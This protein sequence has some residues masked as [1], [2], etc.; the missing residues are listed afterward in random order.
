MININ[1]ELLTKIIEKHLENDKEL[2]NI[3]LDIVN[4]INNLPFGTETSIAQ[5]IDYNPEISFTEPLTQG[6]V[7]YCVQKVCNEINISLEK[8]DKIIGG[9]AYYYSFTKN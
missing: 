9:L 1:N 4:K 5:L 6:K 3:V 8:S 7:S 2:V